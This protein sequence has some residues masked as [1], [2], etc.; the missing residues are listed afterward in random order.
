MD[1]SLRLLRATPAREGSPPWLPA[2]P[3]LSSL[4]GTF[5]LFYYI[6]WHPH[7]RLPPTAQQAQQA[8]HAS[9]PAPA[10]PRAK[11]LYMYGGVG[12]GK[13]MLMD[14]L[15]HSSPPQFKVLPQY[16]A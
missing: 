7:P 8:E 15:A 3:T 11:G 2:L 5:Q 14:L 4:G 9:R 1:A 10:G 13:T 12:V 6:D 16:L